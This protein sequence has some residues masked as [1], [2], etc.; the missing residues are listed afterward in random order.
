MNRLAL[1]DIAV[2]ELGIKEFSHAQQ[3][4]RI[5]QY[6]QETALKV[7]DDETS[8]CA[9]FANWV[10]KQAGYGGTK[11]SAA[12]SFLYWGMEPERAVPGCL[13][14]FKC[15]QKPWQGYVGFYLGTNKDGDIVCLGANPNGCVCIAHYPAQDVL[16]FRIARGV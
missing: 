8:W 5:V 13:A 9:A 10:L 7:S 2:T 4:P 3:N 11:S 16:G 15:G 12:R 1:L 14:V 6:H